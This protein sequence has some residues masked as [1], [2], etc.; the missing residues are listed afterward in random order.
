MCDSAVRSDE[1]TDR[2]WDLRDQRQSR[3]PASPTSSV[4]GRAPNRPS[5]GRAVFT[6]GGL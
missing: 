1:T 4:R 6:A 3:L 2:T 5:E